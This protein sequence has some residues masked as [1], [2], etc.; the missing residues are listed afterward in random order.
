[1]V[2]VADAAA[3]AAAKAGHGHEPLSN[4]PGNLAL[5]I[6]HGSGYKSLLKF[7][8]GQEI[9]DMPSSGLF[10]AFE[11]PDMPVYSPQAPR[12][13]SRACVRIISSAK[14]DLSQGANPDLRCFGQE[15]DEGINSGLISHRLHDCYVAAGYLSLMTFGGVVEEIYELHIKARLFYDNGSIGIGVKSK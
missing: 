10:A 9:I 12:T 3:V 6:S 11:Y 2:Q 13:T 7:A 8:V 15:Y 5:Q 1:M 4:R 14:I